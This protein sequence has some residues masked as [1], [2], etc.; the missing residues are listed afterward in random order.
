MLSHDQI[1][2]ALDAFAARSGLTPS[3]LA[4]KAGLDPTA[5]NRSKR[6]AADGRP[7][8]PSTESIAKVLDATGASLDEFMALIA[9]HGK[10]KPTRNLPLIGFAQAG[11]GGFF[12][13]G[14]FPVGG[15][16][17]EVAFPEIS[18]DKVFALEIAGESMQPVYRDGD[19]I[20]VSPTASLRRG[21]RVVVRTVEG[22]V[23]AKEL[24]R[25]TAKTVELR[26]LNPDH[27]DR[28]FNEQDIAWIARIIWASQ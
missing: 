20:I 3:G 23:M 13:D 8:W 1:W 9:R 25:R 14:G 2:S 24:K 22:E 19:V 12:D 6:T 11:K 17:D 15:S 16:W 10:Y 7:R 4:R 18:E 21:D 26:S 28:M 27:E 5:F